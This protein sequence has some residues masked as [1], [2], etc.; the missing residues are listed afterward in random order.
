MYQQ[1]LL[2]NIQQMKV[3]T[4]EVLEQL[5]TLTDL[6]DKPNPFKKYYHTMKKTL[7]PVLVQLN[8]MEQWLRQE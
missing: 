1:T 2:M 8:D 4:T 6:Y 3:Q 5:K 7:E